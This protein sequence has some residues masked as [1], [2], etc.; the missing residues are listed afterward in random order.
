MVTSGLTGACRAGDGNGALPHA[1]NLSYLTPDN[2][3]VRPLLEP[4]GPRGRV[5]TLDALHAQREA[6]RFLVEDKGADYIPAGI[7]VPPRTGR[8]RATWQQGASFAQPRRDVP[9]WPARPA[10]RNDRPWRII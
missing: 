3:Q 10:E 2:D 8:Q 6:A 7:G 9:A 5:V 1:S 4:L